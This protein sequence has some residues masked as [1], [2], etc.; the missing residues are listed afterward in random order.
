MKK[1]FLLFLILLLLQSGYSQKF[2]STT[3][4][5]I[6]FSNAFLEINAKDIDTKYR[7]TLFYHMESNYNWDFSR[8][9]GLY[10]GLGI[11]NIGLIADDDHLIKYRSYALG[12]PVALKLGNL[13]G[14]TFI[15]GGLEYEMLFHYKEKEFIDGKKSKYTEWFSDRTN[16]FVPSVFFGYQFKGG[17]NFRFK[18]YL[19]N[20]FN[21][22]YTETIDGINTKPY[23]NITSQIYY[24]SLSF[25]IKN[26]R[27]KEKIENRTEFF[28]Y[29]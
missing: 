15:Y 21:Q 3:G 19:D 28:V 13:P 12:L 25:Y 1:I 23:Q 2:Y 24:F 14:N 11:R 5:E 22:D 4:G 7:F 27:I 20:F 16:L 6:I 17:T 18:L 26:T 29:Q 8:F 10:S 9:V